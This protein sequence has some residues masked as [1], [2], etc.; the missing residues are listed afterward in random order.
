MNFEETKRYIVGDDNKIFYSK[1]HVDQLLN[2][3]WYICLPDGEQFGY[4]GY[5]TA[6]AAKAQLTIL[7]RMA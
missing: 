7:K 3:K 6:S 1:L 4:R 2:G 5:K